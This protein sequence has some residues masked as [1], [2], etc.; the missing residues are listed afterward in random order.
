MVCMIA[1]LY[2]VEVGGTYFR[3]LDFLL[4]QLVNSATLS[5]RYS[6]CSGKPNVAPLSLDDVEIV[7]H[8]ESGGA[9]A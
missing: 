6:P 1:G 5:T 2:A 9:G 4:V 7:G 8:G 3:G